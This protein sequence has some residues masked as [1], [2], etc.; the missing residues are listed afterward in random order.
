MSPI[1]ALLLKRL[2]AFPLAF[3]GYRDGSVLECLVGTKIQLKSRHRVPSGL[4]NTTLSTD[5]KNLFCG[6]EDG[7]IGSLDVGSSTFQGCNENHHDWVACCKVNFDQ[8]I[9]V[10]SSWDTSIHLWQSKQGK[11][12]RSLK[13]GSQSAVLALGMMDDML[14]AG[15]YDGSIHI[16]RF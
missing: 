9:A 14:V 5:G 3:L 8:Q 1:P 7:N 15:A 11:I 4:M 2:L 13:T 12:V 16:W 10:S 6:F